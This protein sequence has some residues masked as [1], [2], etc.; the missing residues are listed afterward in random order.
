M[1]VPSPWE[2]CDRR[3]R[4]NVLRALRHLPDMT[5]DAELLRRART[6]AHAFR[7]LYD[8]YAA[9]VFTFHRRRARDVDA[10]HDL[11]AETFAQAWEARKRF[12]DEPA[13]PARPWLVR[14]AR[15]MP[16]TAVAP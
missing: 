13:G 4:R 16:G 14:I 1:A 6:D 5:T 8:R 10:A 7:E 15:H 3:P 9:R 11:T 12:R 2:K